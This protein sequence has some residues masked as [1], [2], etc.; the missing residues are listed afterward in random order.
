MDL[1]G[2]SMFDL[3]QT[4]VLQ[5]AATLADGLVALEQRAS[6]PKLVEPL[7]RAAHSIKGAARIVNLD[8]AVHL[9]HA[10]EECL[11]RVQKG[12]ERPTPERIDQLLKGSDTLAAIAQRTSEDDARLWLEQERKTIIAL[13]ECFSSSP[14]A[15]PSTQPRTAEHFASIEVTAARPATPPAVP[16]PA[17]TAAAPIAH[18]A[19]VLVSSSRLDRILELSG[20]SLVETRR[21]GSVRRTLTRAKAAQR[22]LADAL[23]LMSAPSPAAGAAIGAAATSRQALDDALAQVEEHLRRGEEL[24]SALHHEA[25]SSR[26]RPFGDACG[27]FPRSVRDIARSLGKDVRVEVLGEQV[28]VDREILRQLEAPLGHLIRNAIDHGI[29]SP[30]ERTAK[31]KPRQASLRV[32]AGHHAG[33]LVV[34][35]RDDG[36]G[37]DRERLRQRIAEKGLAEQSTLAALDDSELFDF[38][39]LPGLSTAEKVTDISGRGVGLDVVQSM[40]H[41]VGGS[42]DVRSDSEGTSFALR[43]PVTLSVVRAAV[44][45]IG[46]EPYAMALSRLERIDRI[47]RNAISMVEGRPAFTIRGECVGIVG[48][49][50]LLETGTTNPAPQTETVSIIS[51]LAGQRT[52]GLMVDDFLGEEDLV[53]RRL[54]PRLGDVAHVDAA[55]IRESGELL[56][57]LDTDD[58]VQSAIQLLEQGRLRG[59]S[60]AS[61]TRASTVRRVLVVEDSI[62]VREVERQMLVRAGYAVETAVDGVD[63]WNALQKGGYDLVVS[64]I[65][66][67]RMNGIELVKR[68]RADPRFASIPVVIV[69]YKDR[70]EDRLAGMEAGAS[71]YLTKGSFQ[72]RSFLQTIVGLIGEAR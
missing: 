23:D 16:H 9:A 28:P 56:L 10:M 53:V 68:L 48:A 41:A 33:G 57:I 55:S 39:F 42:V 43:L 59:S 50:E 72:D 47:E 32:R 36:R 52:I 21:L 12:Q 54:D 3:F 14:A 69:S 71:A 65:D 24:A 60:V 20:E 1:G 49:E 11:I 25:V 46:G 31:G 61:Q 30:D 67:P 35:V 22:Q 2:F 62:T 18:S 19:G 45:A 26:M 7:M 27:T 44:V 4:E 38:L 29:E 37:I 17:P 63:G 15:P 8:V 5:H 6:D 64:D 40:V 70:D 66:M 58:L 34:E 13:S 51:V